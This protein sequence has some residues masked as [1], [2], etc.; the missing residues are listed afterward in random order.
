MQNSLALSYNWPVLTNTSPKCLWIFFQIHECR[1]S[2]VQFFVLFFFIHR[3][4]LYLKSRIWNAALACFS[5]AVWN[6]YKRF[7]DQQPEAVVWEPAFCLCTCES[8]SL[9]IGLCC[10]FSLCLLG[11]ICGQYL[12]HCEY[13][14]IS[15]VP[16]I[17][18][19]VHCITISRFNLS[20]LVM[21]AFVS[22]SV[23][24]VVFQKRLSVF[25]H[26]VKNLSTRAF[27]SSAQMKKDYT[28]NNP[29]CSYCLAAPRHRPFFSIG[30]VAHYGE[31]S[32]TLT[33]SFMHPKH[34]LK[35]L[36][37][38]QSIAASR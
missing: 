8:P 35:H 7:V 32:L 36:G 18:T 37:C 33:H 1:Y 31:K 34:F 24:Y 10:K 20:Y 25:I 16:W 11:Q 28:Q 30:T 38:I 19:C 26:L 3:F 21:C 12:V 5:K 17:S 15:L 13:W 9:C 14:F 22:C 6:T 29:D 23:G 2:Y 4:P 27:S